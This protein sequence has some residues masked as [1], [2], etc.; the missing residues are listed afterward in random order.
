MLHHSLA[1]IKKRK[2]NR[3]LKIILIS[4]L[5]TVIG[6]WIIYFKTSRNDYSKDLNY[7]RKI[8]GLKFSNNL[9]NIEIV[10][11][12]E[13]ITCINFKLQPNDLNDFI[14]INKFRKQ[15]IEENRLLINQYLTEKHKLTE[16]SDNLYSVD[17]LSNQNA[18]IFLVDSLK[19]EVWGQIL[20][21]DWSHDSPSEINN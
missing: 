12:A 1:P 10:D 16:F 4:I 5:A 8:T 9:R 3:W 11:N 20:Y 2:M 15:K 18:W 21:P 14:Q 6:L 13:F 19:A 17:S 7:Y